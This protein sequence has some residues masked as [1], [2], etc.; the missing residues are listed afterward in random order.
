MIELGIPGTLLTFFP[1]PG[2]LQGRQGWGQVGQVALEISQGA[3]S[4]WERCLPQAGISVSAAR[5]PQYG[6]VLDFT[7]SDGLA[8]R[9]IPSGELPPLQL[10]KI[11]SS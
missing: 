4:F 7:D 5:D 2:A 9:F 1:F 8:L 10:P 3:G 6:E 11:S